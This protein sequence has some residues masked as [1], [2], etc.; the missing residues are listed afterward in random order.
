MPDL[1]IKWKVAETP[2]RKWRC[3][4]PRGWPAAFY[5]NGDCCAQILCNDEYDPSNIRTRNHSYLTLMIANYNVNKQLEGRF[6]WKKFA[7]TFLTLKEAKDAVT[8][9]LTTL[10][11]LQIGRKD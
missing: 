11:Q 9:I 5:E 10:P 2:S 4:H 8:K 3:F 1:K 7:A 6:K